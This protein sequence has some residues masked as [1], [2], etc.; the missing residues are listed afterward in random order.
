MWKGGI[1]EHHSG[2]LKISVGKKKYKLLHRKIMEDYL[3]RKLLRSEDVHHINENKKDN[4]I[5]NLQV[6]SKSEHSSLHN[7][8]G[9]RIG[10]K[11]KGL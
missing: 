8:K 10:T 5:E 4:R 1:T 9:R 2:Y 11:I 3:G 6:M 7:S